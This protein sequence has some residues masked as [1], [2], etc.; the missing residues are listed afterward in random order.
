MKPLYYVESIKQSENSTTALLL[1]IPNNI[2]KWVNVNKDFRKYIKVRLTTDWLNTVR[3]GRFVYKINDN[4]YEIANNDHR[5]AQIHERYNRLIENLTHNL[6]AT[7]RF[8]YDKVYSLYSYHINVGHGNHSLIIFK[9]IGK[10]H[11]WMIDCSDYDF[12]SHRYY[13]NNIKDCLDHIRHKFQLADPIHIDVVMLTHAHYDHYSGINYYINTNMIDNRTKAYINLRY[14]IASHNFNNLLSQLNNIRIQIIEPFSHNS[15]D[16]IKILHPNLQNL[17]N[18]LSLNNLSSVYNISFDEK[19][20]FVFPGDL[21][22]KGW[23][24]IDVNKCCP[25]MNRTKYYAISHHGSINGHLRKT[26]CHCK[27]API[28][29]I[30]DCLHRNTITVLMGRDNAFSGIYS[31]KV[32]NDFNG[33]VLLSEKDPNNNRARFLEIDMLS[34]IHKWY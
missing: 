34:D 29:N 1:Y 8:L 28:N 16:N 7:P 5:V 19:S 13:C 21:E 6:T 2:E 31:Q 11:I 23:C 22:E 27:N 9:S 14:K 24:L 10:V 20:Y 17:N 26:F 15:C 18:N 4:T 12:I 3:E 33:R 30:K 25:Y 32:L